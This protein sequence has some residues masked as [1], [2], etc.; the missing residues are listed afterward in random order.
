MEVTT[1]DRHENQ[2]VHFKPSKKEARRLSWLFIT[3]R[4]LVAGVLE[5]IKQFQIFMYKKLIVQKKN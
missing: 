2:S 4:K 1:T 3:K 5:Q